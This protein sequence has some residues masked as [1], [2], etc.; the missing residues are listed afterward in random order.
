MCELDGTW[1]RNDKMIF[2]HIYWWPWILE[3]KIEMLDMFNFFFIKKIEI[4]RVPKSKNKNS[5]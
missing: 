1:T 3:N 4:Y 5:N 2:Y